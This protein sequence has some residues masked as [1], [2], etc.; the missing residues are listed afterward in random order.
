MA[1]SREIDPL[2]KDLTEKNQSFRRNVVSLATEL[3][4][5]RSRLATREQSF[6]RETL[7]RQ[8]SRF[9]CGSYLVD[10]IVNQWNL[11]LSNFFEFV[12]LCDI[13]DWD[14]RVFFLFLQ[15]AEIR[16]RNME[17]E[18][19]R[20]RKS[21]DERNGQLLATASTAEKVK[22]RWIM[23]EF[24]TGLFEILIAFSTELCRKASF[25]YI[26]WN[27]LVKVLQF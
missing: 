19:Y 9:V 11:V 14:L 7:T 16:A 13:C 2:L 17:D 8:V 20:L 23:Y 21:L 15:E 12:L 24:M 25:V 1:S 27:N 5:V 6:V 18:I 26:H 3:K 22:S 4:D 10:I